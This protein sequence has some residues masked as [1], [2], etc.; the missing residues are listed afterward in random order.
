MLLRLVCLPVAN[1]FLVHCSSI[2]FA[3]LNEL[4]CDHAMILF[5]RILVEI[6]ESKIRSRIQSYTI[7]VLIY[8]H[9]LFLRFVSNNY[10]RN[11]RSSPCNSIINQSSA[12]S[13]VNFKRDVQENP[14]L[15]KKY[16]QKKCHYSRVC[17]THPRSLYSQN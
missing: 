17:K 16:A 9:S 13:T 5:V 14:V 1:R 8:F 3:Q 11:Y 4:Q 6:S 2:T 15:S 10:T 7:N 12:N